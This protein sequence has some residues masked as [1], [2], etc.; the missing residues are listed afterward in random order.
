MIVKRLNAPVTE[1]YPGLLRRVL[2]RNPRLMMVEHW[3]AAGATFPW[4]EHP[5]EQLAFIVSG[6][7][8]IETPAGAVVAEA[9]DSF[10]I[11]GGT[12]H[13]VIALEES[14][15]LDVFTPERADYL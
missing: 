5:H 14:L 9:G 3:H 15:A 8:Q 10:V 12:P 11:P 2:A 4:H 6:R 1:A 13:R 7:L